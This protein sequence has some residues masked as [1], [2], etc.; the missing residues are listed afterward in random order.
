MQTY[1]MLCRL[2][3][4]AKQNAAAS[5]KARDQLFEEFAKKGVKVTAY[6]TLGPYDV[7][8]VVEAPS[9]EVMMQFLMGAGRTGNIESVTLRAF[10][11]KEIPRS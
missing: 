10:S 11:E 1:I 9:E 3:A 8:N 4:Q 6:T 5:L 2:T 7:V